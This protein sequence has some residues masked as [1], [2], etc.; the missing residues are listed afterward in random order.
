MSE[1]VRV[2]VIGAGAWGTALAL[3]A[4]R[5][6]HDTVMWAREPEVVRDINAFH[7]NKIFLPGYELPSNL[8]ASTDIAEVCRHADPLLLSVVPTP[9]VGKVIGGLQEH[10][11]DRHIICS[12]SKGIENDSLETVDEILQRVLPR[13]FHS[14]LCFLSG[15]SFAKEVAERSPTAVTIASH[16][17]SVAVEAQ[18]LMAS[19]EHR[20]RC[21]ASR[22]VVG[23]EMGGAL[24]NVMAIATGAAD[25]MG[26][27]HNARA[28]LITRGLAEITKLAVRKGANPLTLQGLAGMGDL[29]LTC[30]GDLSRNRQVGLRLGRGETL[31]QILSGRVTVAEGVLTCRSAWQLAQQLEV[32]AP[33]IENCYRVLYEQRPL[34]DALSDLMHRPLGME[35]QLN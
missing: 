4:A 31:E 24:K 16:I 26:F 35:L 1:K 19:P 9:H 14:A 18:H 22:D 21:Y 3:H 7:E 20:F 12:C 25:G 11:D 33:I 2:G 8:S 17:A 28:A 13:R 23:V 5:R 34:V 15:P 6:G 30:T 29:V 10:L 32:E 27:G